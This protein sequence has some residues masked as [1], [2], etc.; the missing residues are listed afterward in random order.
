MASTLIPLSVD[1]NVAGTHGASIACQA[2]PWLFC[3]GWV[4][5]VSALFAKLWRINKI[6]HA[7]Q[8]RRVVVTKY[9]VLPPFIALLLSNIIILTVWTVLAP[10]KWNRKIVSIDKFT[11]TIES[12]GQC[13]S[14]GNDWLV[15]IILLIVV[16]GALLIFGNYQA[17]RAR[18]ISTEFSESRYVALAMASIFQVFFIG[19]PLMA[20]V[21]MPSAQ[22]FVRAGIVI[23]ICLAV[24]LLVFVP[25]IVHAR[26][27]NS[28]PS[29]TN[30]TSG[31][32]TDSDHS[33]GSDH[34]NATGMKITNN[35]WGG[36]SGS[37]GHTDVTALTKKYTALLS[38]KEAW[39][40]ERERLM[41][42]LESALAKPDTSTNE[43]VEPVESGGKNDE[44]GH[45]PEQACREPISHSMNIELENTSP[46][47]LRS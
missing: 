32:S 1:D 22:L 25:K 37:S 7:K 18:S 42:A 14:E 30:T 44:D 13:I 39:E 16:N 9:D 34:S 23:V 47:D 38:E 45:H 46:S 12:F 8:F 5:S 6:F 43:E 3:I 35:D 2:S 20:L 31:P 40:E 15:Y 27:T 21:V 36:A 4:I 24:Q 19:I 11:R 26:N 17:Y 29:R 10:L 41:G 33:A 28:H